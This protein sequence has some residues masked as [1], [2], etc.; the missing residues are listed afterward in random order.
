MSRIRFGTLA[1]AETP[2]SLLDRLIDRPDAEAW[3]RFVGLYTPY[4][5]G[6]LRRDP[7]LRDDAEDLVR[8]VLAVVRRELPRFE[9]RRTGSF[10]AWLRA[11]TV[12]RLQ[13]L[14]RSRK[15]VPAGPGG[16]ELL[17]ALADPNSEL[18]RQRDRDHDL[19]VAHRLLDQATA[20]FEPATVRA[21]RMLALEGR[22]SAEVASELKLARN[23]VF[24][25]K[26][27]ILRRLRELSEG[28][29]D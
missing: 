6:W 13:V 17:S 9:R 3:R 18:S 28:L 23:A 21:F 8:G 24:L 4:L 16:A 26:S 7:G 25:A 1:V 15:A 11:V 12:N 2:L 5:L 19:Y 27:R 20:D 14:L 29:I 22:A 10:S